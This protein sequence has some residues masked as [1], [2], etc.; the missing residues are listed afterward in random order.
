VNE[1]TN[2][3]ESLTW[4]VFGRAQVISVLL[5]LLTVVDLCKGVNDLV[6]GQQPAAAVV[7]PLLLLLS[8]VREVAALPLL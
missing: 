6:T 8:F 5:A 1:C 4:C 2:S 7:S 3:W